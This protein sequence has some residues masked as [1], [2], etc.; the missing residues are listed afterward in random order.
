MDEKE[1]R[2][3]AGL[4]NE[5]GPNLKKIKMLSDQLVKDLESAIKNLP[6]EPGLLRGDESIKSRLSSVKG[7]LISLNNFLKAKRL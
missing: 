6:E 7:A 2:K 5:A 1:L 3:L 4:L